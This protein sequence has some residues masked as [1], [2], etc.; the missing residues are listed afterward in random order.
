MNLNH[1]NYYTPKADRLYMSNSQYKAWMDCPARQTAKMLGKWYED[2][3]MAFLIGKYV[4]TALLTPDL[5]NG[6]VERNH[7][8]LFTTRGDKPRAET[9]LADGMID[10]CKRDE[11]FMGALDGDHQELVTWEMFGIKWRALFDAVD[12]KRGTLVDLKTV[13]DFE[14]VWCDKTRAR[15]PFYERYGYWTQLAIYREAYKSKAGEYPK[16]TAIA[17]VSK[18]KFPRLK[19]IQFDNDERFRHELEQIETNLPDILKW[20][21]A[22][23]LDDAPKCGK[24]DYCA[25]RSESKMEMAESLKW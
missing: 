17:A 12:Y 15:L 25:D 19:V 18:H 24:C 13:K 20:R 9:M 11:L 21:K 1:D 14:P 22:L 7:M 8:S 4:D 23:S 3:P 2:E 6:F 10:R 5:L 16:V